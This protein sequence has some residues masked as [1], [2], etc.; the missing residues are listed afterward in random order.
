[1]FNN[2]EQVL[3]VYKSTVKRYLKKCKRIDETIRQA[4]KDDYLGSLDWP[5]KDWEWKNQTEQR[6]HGMAV[7][8]GLSREEINNIWEVIKKEV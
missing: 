6:M 4:R 7:A 8:L 1:M 2:I 3:R 5:K